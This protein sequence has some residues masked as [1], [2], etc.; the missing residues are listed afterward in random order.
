MLKRVT[1]VQCNAVSLY[2]T[3]A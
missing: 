1:F 2:V 3:A